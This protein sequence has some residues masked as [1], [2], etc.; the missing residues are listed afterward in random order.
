MAFVD[1]LKAVA[2]ATAVFLGICALYLPSPPP[3]PVRA[4]VIPVCRPERLAAD[5]QPKTCSPACKPKE[6]CI[7]G[8]CCQP[9]SSAAVV[10]WA[11]DSL[12]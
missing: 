11:A 8:T 9:A 12:R 1:K 3:R 6:V 5:V 4:K 7:D 10:V 2:A